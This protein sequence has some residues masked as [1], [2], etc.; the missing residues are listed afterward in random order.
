MLTVARD[1]RTRSFYTW[2]GLIYAGPF[3]PSCSLL[4]R[5]SLISRGAIFLLGVV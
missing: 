5:C 3:L 4:T 1:V 2:A